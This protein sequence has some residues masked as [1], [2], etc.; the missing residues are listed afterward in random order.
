MH[1]HFSL[2]LKLSI[3][4]RANTFWILLGHRQV[5]VETEDLQT[6]RQD[7]GPFWCETIN[8]RGLLIPDP[9]PFVLKSGPEQW[10]HLCV[11]SRKQRPIWGWVKTYYILS[12]LVGWTSIYH[13]LPS[14]TIIYQLFWV[15]LGVRVLTHSNM[16]TKQMWD[17]TFNRTKNM[18]LSENGGSQKLLCSKGKW[19][20]TIKFGVFPSIFRQSHINC[21]SQL[22]LQRTP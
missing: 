8:T 5:R 11:I 9:W 22:K 12:I 10:R 20:S 15:S 4:G 13:H 3:L 7:L 14:F 2:D 16:P 18:G 21:G 6:T 1:G 17:T 19:W